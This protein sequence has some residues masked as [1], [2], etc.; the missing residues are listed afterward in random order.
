MWKKFWEEGKLPVFE[1][2]V[3]LDSGSITRASLALFLAG[4]LI[5]LAYFSIK[6][7]AK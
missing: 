6:K 4:F 1:T 5:I 3:G 2:E 7:I